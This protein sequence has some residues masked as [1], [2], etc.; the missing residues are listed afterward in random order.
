MHLKDQQNMKKT[1]DLVLV[2]MRLVVAR[3]TPVAVLEV[4]ATAIPEG[5]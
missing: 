4:I 5:M 1:T 3:T 2:K